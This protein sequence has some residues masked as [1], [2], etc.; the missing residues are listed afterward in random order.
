MA[1]PKSVWDTQTAIGDTGPR[2]KV[3]TGFS[4]QIR[5]NGYTIRHNGEH[6]ASF[7]YHMPDAATLAKLSF[8]DTCTVRERG[9][10]QLFRSGHVIAYVEL[11]KLE[12]GDGAER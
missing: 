2:T 7:A 6:V 1:D 5:F 10:V 8:L 9:L 4:N 11:D 12:Q 3:R